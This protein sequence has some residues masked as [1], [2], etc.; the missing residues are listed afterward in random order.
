MYVR[1]RGYQVIKRIPPEDR[2]MLRRKILAHDLLG[3]E[4]QEWGSGRRWYGD[5]LSQASGT[6]GAPIRGILQ[7]L[8]D[9]DGGN[10]II[11]SAQVS[12]IK[13]FFILVNRFELCIDN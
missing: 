6:G 12:S 7:E 3:R 9:K 10:N 5:Y 13:V 8:R 2:D 1:W 4:R 11:F